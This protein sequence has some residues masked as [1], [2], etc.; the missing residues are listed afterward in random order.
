MSRRACTIVVALL[1]VAVA[2]GLAAKK[3]IRLK[4][5]RVIVGEV[6]EKTSE[7]VKVK[8]KIA[9]EL[10]KNEDIASIEDVLNP[11]AEYRKRL[12]AIKKGDAKGHV[13]LGQW[14]MDQKM[15]A[16][17]VARFEE[18]LKIDKSNE[19]AKLLL[20]L[21]KAKQAEAG[22]GNN[23][24]GTTNG[25]STTTIKG[26]GF[27]FKDLI[28][29]SD[30]YRIRLEELRENERISVR[31]KGNVI[32]EFLKKMRGTGDFA[33]KGNERKFRRSPRVQ[34]ARYILKTVDR[35]DSIKDKILVMTDPQFMQEFR[36]PVWRWVSSSCASTQCHGAA[37]GQGKLK[38]YNYPGKNDQVDYTNYLILDYFHKGGRRMIARDDWERSLLLQY[39]LP[40]KQ[41]EYR[42][43]KKITPPFSSRETAGHRFTLQWIKKLSGP[44]HPPYRISKLPRFAMKP[45]TGFA[46]LDVSPNSTTPSGGGKKPPAKPDVPF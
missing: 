20:R 2:P 31:F 16:E 13:A 5:G 29:T 35:N 9:V 38:L 42:H 43:P 39:A 21:A 25:G 14:A 45:P 3:R 11:K 8:G 15:Y 12:A 10:I 19:Q 4:S 7:G 27:D 26:P 1:L 33:E 40:T 32:D 28:Q 36:G 44:Q 17:A 23:G 24:G 18:A 34:Q 37:K 46:D 6:I 30:I 22:S 41:A